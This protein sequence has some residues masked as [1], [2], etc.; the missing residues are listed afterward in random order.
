MTKSASALVL[1]ALSVS[2]FSQTNTIKEMSQDVSQLISAHGDKLSEDDKLSVKK[3]LRN[4]LQIFKMN[5][6]GLPT[7][8]S[9]ICDATNN[10]LINVEIKALIHDFSSYEHC[11]EALA[12]VKIGKAFC[13][14]TDNTL[15]LAD[16][17]FAFDFS[18]G[19]NC[20]EAIESIYTV[21]KFCDYTDNTLRKFD[22][23]LLYDFS[24]KE[25]CLKGLN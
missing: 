24:S 19:V 18:D 25:E 14:Y 4:I 9:Y 17:Q 10:Q 6:Q 1:L 13:D 15:R 2:A 23:S 12:N 7:G 11:T 20:K 5:G 16:G 22:G 8:G 3:N 21:K